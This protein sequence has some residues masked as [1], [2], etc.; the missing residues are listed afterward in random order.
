[1]GSMARSLGRSA[2]LAALAALAVGAAALAVGPLFGPSPPPD[3]PVGETRPL[4]AVPVPPPPLAGQVPHLARVEAD[5]TAKAPPAPRAPHAG[6][7]PAPRTL[8]IAVRDAA[9]RPVVGAEVRVEVDGGVAAR[10]RSSA[11]DGVAEVRAPPGPVLAVSVRGAGGPEVRRATD[12]P[13]VFGADDLEGLVLPEHALL[14]VRTVGPRGEPR[15]SERILF[16]PGGGRHPPTDAWGETSDSEG[17]ARLG[18]FA[19]GSVVE[20]QPGPRGTGA[21]WGG[22][23]PAAWRPVE[24]GGREVDLVVNDLPRLRVFVRGAEFGALVPLVLLDPESGEPLHPREHVDPAGGPWMAPALALGRTFELLAGPTG[25]GRLARVAAL[26]PEEDPVEVEL[27][28]GVPLE[29]RALAPGAVR[30]VEG[31][32][33]ARGRGY[34][35]VHARLDER[36]RFRFAGLPN[37]PVTLVVHARVERREGDE[38][39]VHGE[40]ALEE[41][42]FAEVDVAAIPPMPAR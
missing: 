37:G 41:V 6:A 38:L 24:V 34:M 11:P 20:L 2:A 29:G 42:G 39:R 7:D 8:R 15:P 17:F 12:A 9:G 22:P 36:G 5:P 4:A 27:R 35:G 3:S 25:E 30:F 21:P 1:M 18:P 32:V 16:R 40:L 19:L 23:D 14:V 33:Q 26:R 13:S 10:G 31:Q 28:P